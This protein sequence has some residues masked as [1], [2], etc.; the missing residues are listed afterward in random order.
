MYNYH[1]QQGHR[2]SKYP[3]WVA[4]EEE[5]KYLQQENLDFAKLMAGKPDQTSCEIPLRW[6]GDILT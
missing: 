3:G 4:S 1:S 5:D 2:K 6:H